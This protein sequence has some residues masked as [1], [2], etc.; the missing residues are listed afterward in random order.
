MSGKINLMEE[1]P[2]VSPPREKRQ[3]RV[4]EESRRVAEEPNNGFREMT[5]DDYAEMGVERPEGDVESQSPG[6]GLMRLLQNPGVK[7]LSPQQLQNLRMLF[8]GTGGGAGA[9]LG[10][11]YL[12]KAL[13]P[14]W[15][16]VLG[17]AA[18]AYGAGWLAE[19][20]FGKG[21]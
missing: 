21:E 18:G 3:P 15:A 7:D 13:G 16:S 2:W 12:Q 10:M 20:V 8:A 1:Q 6:G 14:K 4:A 5:P 11:K 17:A 9:A 19:R